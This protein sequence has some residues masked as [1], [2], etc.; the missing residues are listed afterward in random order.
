MATASATITAL[1]STTASQQVVGANLFR[2]GLVLHNTDANACYIAYGV[3]ATT[4]PG[5]FTEVINTGETWRMDVPLFTGAI[6]AIWTGN[7]T[8]GLSI[9]EL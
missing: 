7:G 2:T 8:G 4:V 6:N 3:A 1:A 9:T 5:G